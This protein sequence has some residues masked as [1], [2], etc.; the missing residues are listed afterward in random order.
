MVKKDYEDEGEDEDTDG[1]R[2][3]GL[4]SPTTCQMHD[5]HE[6]KSQ[7]WNRTDESRE[8]CKRRKEGIVVTATLVRFDMASCRV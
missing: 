1:E 4:F 8:Q 6:A 3:Q 7:R 5:I 2:R